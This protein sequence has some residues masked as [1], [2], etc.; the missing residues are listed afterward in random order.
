MLSPALLIDARAPD[1]HLQ[2]QLRRA[3]QEL[4]LDVRQATDVDAV[5]DDLRREVAAGAP[6]LLILLGPQLKNPVVIARRTHRVSPLSYLV[7]MADGHR[8]AELHEAISEI[9]LIGSYWSIAMV[10][11]DNLVDILRNAVLSVRQRQ[12][13]RTTLDRIN[14]QLASKLPPDA[15]EQRRYMVSDR[16][17]ACM[18]E[19]ASDAI[20]AT[21]NQGTITAWNRA[22]EQLFSLKERDA[23]GQ[24]VQTVAGGAWAEQLPGLIAQLGAGRPLEG[25]CELPCR[26]LDGTHFDAEL[27]MT[28]VREETGHQIG[29]LAIVRNVTERKRAEERFRRVVEGAPCAM[30]MVDTGGQIVLVN[31]ETERLFGYAREELV[32]QSVERLVPER[33]RDP[34]PGH[35]A[36]FFGDPQIRPM[37]AGRDLYGLRKDGVEVPVEIGLNSLE[38]SEGV[39]VLASIVDI[40]ERKRQTEELQ[41]ANEALERSNLDLQRFAYIASHDLQTPLRSIAGFVQLL[42]SEYAGRLGKQADDWIRRTVQSTEQLQTLIRD[43][44]V[45]SRVDSQAHPFERILFRDVF[46]DAILLLDASIRNSGAQVTCDELPTVM[47]DRSQLA[48]LMQNLIGNALKYRGNTPPCVHVC[49]ERSG[50]EWVFSVLDNG[51]GID[52]KY[53]ERIFEIFQRLHDQQKYPGTGIGLAVCRRVVHHHGGRIWVESEPGHGSVFYFTIPEREISDL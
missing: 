12:Q 39:F 22:A 42:Q 46:D 52:P 40:T 29:I 2:R 5:L 18:L 51:I 20:V 8:A 30:V 26:R 4:G 9:S 17:L 35:R 6:P 15:E 28:P 19:N 13:L 16:F 47:G 49:A 41:R 14:V 48:Q 36:G 21:D 44:L 43:L 31:R 7:L 50:N 10:A 27:L 37:G 34:H 1:D 45:Y 25:I 38:T 32:G 23:I 11:S 3:A 53:H 33:Y 24:S